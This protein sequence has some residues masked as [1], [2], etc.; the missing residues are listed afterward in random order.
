MVDGSLEVTVIQTT[1]KQYY[2]DS[3]CVWEIAYPQIKGLTNSD[4]QLTLNKQFANYVSFGDCEDDKECQPGEQWFPKMQQ[5]WN[6]V[7]L[8]GLRNGLLSYRVSEGG[9]PMGYNKKYGEVQYF[10]YDLDKGEYVELEH[11]FQFDS[12]QSTKFNHL[13][14]IKLGFTPEE[15]AFQTMR[16]YYFDGENLVVY[17]DRYTIGEDEEYHIP[18][19]YV[20][21]KAWMKEGKVLRR[22]FGK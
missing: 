8:V 7:N 16:Q 13:L 21:L 5:Y 11:L 22:Y 1:I 14:T 19:S 18:L 9:Q 3:S 15:E 10:T 4:I 12:L 2:N 20:E 6:K 17:F